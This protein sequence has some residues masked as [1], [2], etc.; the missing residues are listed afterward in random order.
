MR[1]LL[2]ATVLLLAGAPASSA[3]WM[4]PAEGRVV[5]R[6]QVGADPFAAG[7]RRGVDL[8]V[9]AGARVVAPCAGRVAFAGAVP[10]FG[11]GVSVRCGRFTATVL[12]L[13]RAWVRAGATLRRGAGVGEARGGE[14][15]LGARVT[16]DRFGYRDP[17]GL[18]GEDTPARAP[19]LGPRDVARRVAPP[20]RS[21]PLA[22]AHPSRS[23]PEASPSGAPALAWIGV[24]LVACALPGGALAWRARRSRVPL[25]RARLT[26]PR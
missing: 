15:R 9:R 10:R 13:S 22:V 16:T 11:L 24:A 1:A 6:F 4:L 5:G 14:L 8:A 2:L 20:P 21:P 18:I 17:L 3:A 25:A 7:Q 23:S 19:L 12:G 26:R